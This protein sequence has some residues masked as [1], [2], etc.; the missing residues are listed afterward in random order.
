MPGLCVRDAHMYTL[1]SF[2]LRFRQYSC[3]QIATTCVRPASN[4]GLG[5]GRESVTVFAHRYFL[6]ANRRRR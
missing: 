6:S 4:T 1:P 2:T 5:E 3:G